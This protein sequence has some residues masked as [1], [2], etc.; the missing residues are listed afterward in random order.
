MKKQGFLRWPGYVGSLSWSCGGEP[1]GSI[2]F[3]VETARLVLMYRYRS[4]GEEWEDFEEQVWFDRTACNYG[5]ER[6]WFLCPNCGRRVAV[7][8]GAGVRFLCRHCHD[9][10]YA[11]QSEDY[12]SRM[13]RKARKIRVKLD[14]DGDLSELVWEKPKGMHWR[15]FERLV[16]SERLANDAAMAAMAR[17]LSERQA[18]WNLLSLG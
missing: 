10:S 2:R 8:Y 15:T 13:M 14:A 9:L 4:Y 18:D 16:R 1:T 6:L 3:R 7:L 17:W 12:M 5:G 11:S